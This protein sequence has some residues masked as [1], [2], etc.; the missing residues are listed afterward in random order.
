[1]L[2][3]E[4]SHLQVPLLILTTTLFPVLI[5]QWHPSKIVR[6]DERVVLPKFR[7]RWS[8][9]ERSKACLEI[10]AICRIELKVGF[11]GYDVGSDLLVFKV[12]LLE[13]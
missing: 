7:V 9:N 13:S 8:T 11:L 10:L 3:S 2:V 1:M 5:S 6:L 12:W 4:D